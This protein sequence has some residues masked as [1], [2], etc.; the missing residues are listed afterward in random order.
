M[1]I[2]DRNIYSDIRSNQNFDKNIFGSSFGSNIS[3]EYIRIFIHVIFLKQ[4]YS[5]ILSCQNPYDCHTLLQNTDLNFYDME[6]LSA[7]NKDGIHPWPFSPECFTPRDAPCFWQRFPS[8]QNI[9]FPCPFLRF[10]LKRCW[11]LFEKISF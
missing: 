7:N 4:I 6:T 11:L 5:N 10:H 9:F 3:Y 8:K 2:F 1:N